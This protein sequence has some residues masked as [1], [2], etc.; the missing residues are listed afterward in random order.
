[1]KLAPVLEKRGWW[2][3]GRDC[4]RLTQEPAVFAEAA[5]AACFAVA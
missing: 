3:N 2:F 4:V 1:M 5:H